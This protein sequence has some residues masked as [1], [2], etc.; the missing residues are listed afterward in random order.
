MMYP[1]VRELAADGVPVTVTCRVLDLARQPYYRWLASPVTDAELAEAYRANAL[2]DAHTDDP[3]FGHRFL[4]DEAAQAGE[5]MAQRTAWRI[6]NPMR[7]KAKKPGPLVGRIAVETLEGGCG[8]PER[9]DA[10]VGRNG[11]GG[12][13]AGRV[14]GTHAGRVGREGRAAVSRPA[15]R[16]CAEVVP[17][18][19]VASAC[20]AHLRAVRPFGA[21][22]L[23]AAARDRVEEVDVGWNERAR[24]EPF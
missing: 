8:H 5:P 7:G 22:E 13:R 3:E 19:A 14:G 1:L 10:E 20:R 4:V 23:D 11:E 15:A 18:S 17:S 16:E 6:C 12:P 24:G 2:F 21:V 9:V